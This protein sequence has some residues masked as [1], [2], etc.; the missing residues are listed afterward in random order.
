[1]VGEAGRLGHPRGGEVRR[2][3][4]VGGDPAAGDDP[5]G[6]LGDGGRYRHDS[7]AVAVHDADHRADAT[8]PAGLV[9][10]RGTDDVDPR[11]GRRPRAEQGAE[12][13]VQLVHAG[14]LDHERT[15][16]V[17][18]AMA[19][20][21]FSSDS[22]PPCRAAVTTHVAMCSPSSSSANDSSAFVAADTWVNTSIQYV[23]DSTIR[24]R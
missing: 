7:G 24:C 23:S 4:Q 14:L 3:V 12:V 17:T 13:L 11:C 22:A 5:A 21:T 16:R 9:A 6:R 15:S 2:V 19:S 20:W 1:M 8:V 18:A 10:H